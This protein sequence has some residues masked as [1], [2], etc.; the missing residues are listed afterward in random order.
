MSHLA[1]IVAW[2]VKAVYKLLQVH[3][4]DV[5]QSFVLFSELYFT[6][7]DLQMYGSEKI[8]MKHILIRDALG[9]IGLLS[10]LFSY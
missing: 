1:F 7:I 9:E 4:N 3:F 5:Y 10:Q 2:K 8:G 6:L